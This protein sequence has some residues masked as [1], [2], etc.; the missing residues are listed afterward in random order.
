MG[1]KSKMP[2]PP[3]LTSTMV[4]GGASGPLSCC[5]AFKS[6]IA[7]TSPIINVVASSAPRQN[8]AAVL[9]TPSIPD[10]P[11]LAIGGTGG[12]NPSAYGLAKKSKSRIGMELEI[13]R[14]PP[15]RNRRE[16]ACATNG[17]VKSWLCI[18]YGSK[19]SAA[20]SDK[21][22]QNGGGAWRSGNPASVSAS[23]KACNVQGMWCVAM[24]SWSY[25][26]GACA[27]RTCMFAAA[28]LA[29]PFS[30]AEQSG[31][32]TC[33]KTSTCNRSP[34]RRGQWSNWSA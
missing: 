19:A 6:W 21:R 24:W 27:T 4:N 1:K 25:R 13:C 23:A 26:P 9:I 11:R 7:D 12:L 3:L 33:I 28:D 29:K 8:P 10:A 31:P 5:S 34:A 15:G 22:F 30:L 32:P 17:S 14:C 20:A 18:K 2:P 16:T